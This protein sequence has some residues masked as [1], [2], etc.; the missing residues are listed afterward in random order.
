MELVCGMWQ[1]SGRGTRSWERR[2][3]GTYR[4]LSAIHTERICPNDHKVSV[5]AFCVA[6][7]KVSTWVAKDVSLKNL[8]A[9]T[10]VNHD[11]LSACDCL[12]YQLALMLW[13]DAK[14]DVTV[15]EFPQN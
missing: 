12:R 6:Y 8:E 2:G 13:N 1:H 14:L 15:V 3:N 4:L 11:R 7:R 9:F 5:D 10:V